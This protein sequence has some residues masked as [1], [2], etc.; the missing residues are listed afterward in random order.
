MKI[1]ASQAILGVMQVVNVA[2][3]QDSEQLARAIRI[4]EASYSFSVALGAGYVTK[5]LIFDVPGLTIHAFFNGKGSRWSVVGVVCGSVGGLTG[6]GGWLLAYQANG[7][8]NSA[9]FDV[10]AILGNISCSALT[11]ANAASAVNF[12]KDVPGGCG[13]FVRK[14]AEAAW[15]LRTEKDI[16]WSPNPSGTT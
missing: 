6:I 13:R 2:T 7:S 5:V 12:I 10:A 11:A 4:N 9:S 16:E 15:Q 14:G 1:V 3:A 8:S